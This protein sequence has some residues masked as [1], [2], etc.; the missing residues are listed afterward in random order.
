V[1]N[2]NAEASGRRTLPRKFA[3]AIDNN[4]IAILNY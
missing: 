2:G 1:W 3:L 4:E